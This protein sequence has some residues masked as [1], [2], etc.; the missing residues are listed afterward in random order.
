MGLIR[1]YF[2]VMLFLILNSAKSQIVPRCLC[3]NSKTFTSMIELRENFIVRFKVLYTDHGLDEFIQFGTYELQGD[4][5]F[6]HLEGEFLPNSSNISTAFTQGSFA[7]YFKNKNRLIVRDVVCRE[8]NCRAYKR[9][10][11]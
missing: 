3:V 9:S 10:S 5:L 6:I 7:G 4:S 1:L 11:N 2:I 8:A